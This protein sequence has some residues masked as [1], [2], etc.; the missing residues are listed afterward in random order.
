MDVL[1]PFFIIYK[2]HRNILKC[3]TGHVKYIQMFYYEQWEKA[4]SNAV[5][6]IEKKE[7][8]KSVYMPRGAHVSSCYQVHS[9]QNI[10]LHLFM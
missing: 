9:T 3:L 1:L 8:K 6:I 5:G 4:T 10:P 7:E 2:A